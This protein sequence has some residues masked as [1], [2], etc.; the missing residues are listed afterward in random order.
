M[1]YPSPVTYPS[2]SLYPGTAGVGC[3][4]MVAL[5]DLVLGELDG[6]GV[7]WTVSKFDGWGST[8]PTLQLAQR[9]RGHGATASES[10]LNPPT[11]TI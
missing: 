1:P 2:P 11:N 10:F 8:A 9:A 4:L 7:R 5:G 6:Y 3:E